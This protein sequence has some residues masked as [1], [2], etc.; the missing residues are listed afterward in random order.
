VS[1]A[2]DSPLRQRPAGGGCGR[3]ESVT[4]AARPT[5]RAESVLTYLDRSS[6]PT[7]SRFTQRNSAAGYL[8]KEKL[9]AQPSYLPKYR[10]LLTRAKSKSRLG[11]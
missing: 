11:S 5:S 6:S 2:A 8:S 4:A 10:I 3:E 9:G 7:R 1:P